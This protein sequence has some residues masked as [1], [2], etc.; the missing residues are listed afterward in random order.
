[1][2]PTERDIW[3]MLAK[4][5]PNGK[6]VQPG[7]DLVP[8][9]LDSHEKSAFAEP[10]DTI[11]M[12]GPYCFVIERPDHPTTDPTL[13]VKWVGNEHA[14]WLNPGALSGMS[15]ARPAANATLDSQALETQIDLIGWA[16]FVKGETERQAIQ[17]LMRVI[18]PRDLF[19]G[20]MSQAHRARPGSSYRQFA[21]GTGILH[22]AGWSRAQRQQRILH[23]L[24]ESV[25]WQ[26]GSDGRLLVPVNGAGPGHLA[27]K[28]EPGALGTGIFKYAVKV[29][30][31]VEVYTI[32]H[33]VTIPALA[34]APV[35]AKMILL[36]QYLVTVWDHA[37]TVLV[38]EDRR[39]V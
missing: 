3:D 12:A 29:P 28:I 37:N 33:T 1:M 11:F 34:D 22:A 25:T 20:G 13:T 18:H 35:V 26:E 30:A 9:D 6:M 16:G 21:C 19:P 5:F 31:G 38:A 15:L 8:V 27:G 36:E 7:H 39:L 10:E 17:M 32:K 2:R 24:F 4:V 14:K 23:E